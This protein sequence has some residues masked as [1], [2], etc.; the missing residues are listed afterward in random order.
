MAAGKSECRCEW[1]WGS[2]SGFQ[3]SPLCCVLTNGDSAGSAVVSSKALSSKPHLTC[4]VY[5]QAP[6]PCHYLEMRPCIQLGY[7]WKK[8]IKTQ[9]FCIKQG[10]MGNPDGRGLSFCDSPKAL[11]VTCFCLMVCKRETHS[12]YN[13]EES[14]LQLSWGYE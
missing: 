10:W 8:D 9:S 2:G 3:L 12:T 14:C 4:T 6:F 5:P 1:T 11:L 7:R 13:Q